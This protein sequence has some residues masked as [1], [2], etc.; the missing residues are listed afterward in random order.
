M[1]RTEASAAATGPGR[2]RMTTLEAIAWLALAR[3]LVRW[4][5]F[6][7]WRRALGRPAVPPTFV[8]G[9]RRDLN[10]SARRLARAVERAAARLPGESRCLPQALAL[11]W[12]LRR[13]GMDGVLVI[14]IRPGT[15]RGGLDDLHAWVAREGE[16]LIGAS[17]EPHHAL[18]AAANPSDA[19]GLP[20]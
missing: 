8:P 2:A 14:G 20:S 18:L 3:L 9:A 10:L 11:H 12:M 13:R 16:V 6:G 1:P 7:R 4:V 17:D 5:R 19:G 15:S